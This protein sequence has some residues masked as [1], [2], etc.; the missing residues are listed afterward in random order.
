MGMTTKTVERNHDYIT[1][2]M[3]VYKRRIMSKKTIT[4][5]KRCAIGE[6]NHRKKKIGIRK[7]NKSSRKKTILLLKVIRRIERIL[8]GKIVWSATKPSRHL[9]QTSH[10]MVSISSFGY[11]LRIAKQ[12]KKKMRNA[13]LMNS[14][15]G[16]INKCAKV[17][18]TR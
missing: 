17:L 3:T 11:L 6:M 9:L 1:G 15:I 8:R 7:S 2:D 16:H 18:A 12:S 4:M 14:G 13:L 10:S 5:I